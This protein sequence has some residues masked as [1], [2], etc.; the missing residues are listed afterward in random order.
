MFLSDSLESTTRLLH[1]P[2][3][4]NE[5]RRPRKSETR[6]V[7]TQAQAS[8]AAVIVCVC[9][10]CFVYARRRYVQPVLQTVREGGQCQ[11]C[12]AIWMLGGVQGQ[13][14]RPPLALPA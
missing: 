10:V 12:D 7:V 11:W 2:T 9:D 6:N 8:A 3:N 4:P 14:P 1:Q 13:Y 5:S